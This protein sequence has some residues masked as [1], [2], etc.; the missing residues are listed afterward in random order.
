MTLVLDFGQSFEN[1]SNILP[2]SITAIRKACYFFDGL[3][4]SLLLVIVQPSI[5]WRVGTTKVL[6]TE[7]E[8]LSSVSRRSSCN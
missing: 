4:K 3:A 5:N 8:A 7:E 1:R 6:A 2:V